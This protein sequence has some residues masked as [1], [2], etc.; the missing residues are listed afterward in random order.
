MSSSS[1]NDRWPCFSE[2]EMITGIIGGHVDLESLQ[3]DSGA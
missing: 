2:A 3:F 1:S